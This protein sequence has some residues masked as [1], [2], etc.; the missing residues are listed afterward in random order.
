MVSH[1]LPF[2]SE[3]LSFFPVLMGEGAPEGRVRVL[4]HQSFPLE[5]FSVTVRLNT[6]LSP[7]VSGST[8]K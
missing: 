2:A 8:Q 1:I 5:S 6:S 3:T 4:L 7:D